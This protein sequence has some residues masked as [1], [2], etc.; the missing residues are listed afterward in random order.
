M[1]VWNTLMWAHAP[2][3]LLVSHL[4]YTTYKM[5]YNDSRLSNK[6]VKFFNWLPYKC[7][8]FLAYQVINLEILS[9]LLLSPTSKLNYGKFWFKK[10]IYNHL[11]LFIHLLT[12][13]LYIFMVSSFILFFVLSILLVIAIEL[14]LRLSKMVRF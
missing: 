6:G 14:R 8:L 7:V 5:L 12:T 9:F 13:G 1:I 3:Q 4:L 2:A 10:K 11:I